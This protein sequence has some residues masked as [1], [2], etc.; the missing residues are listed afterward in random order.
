MLIPSY[1]LLLRYFCASTSEFLNRSSHMITV[2][3]RKL[4]WRRHHDN[5]L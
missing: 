2:N 3:I 4:R 5:P 1:V